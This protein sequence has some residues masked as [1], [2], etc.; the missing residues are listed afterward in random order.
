MRST[1][2]GPRPAAQDQRPAEIRVDRGRMPAEQQDIVCLQKQLRPARA[3]GIAQ[4][5]RRTG[6]AG[7]REVGRQQGEVA[8]TGH[9][10]DQR[11]LQDR[12][13]RVDRV[14][15]QDQPG[16]DPGGAQ[17]GQRTTRLGD[18][19]LVRPDQDKRGGPRARRRHQMRRWKKRHRLGAAQRSRKPQQAGINARARI[20]EQGRRAPIGA[21]VTHDALVRHDDIVSGPF[22]RRRNTGQQP[23]LVE[24]RNGAASPPAHCIQNSALGVDGLDRDSAQR[25]RVPFTHGTARA[26]RGLSP[27]VYQ[28]IMP[29]T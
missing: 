18:S 24:D 5:G 7:R 23:G 16:P 14:V 10:V 22:K 25:S 19:D 12:V 21:L 11:G 26:A 9:V 6:H 13:S 20:D 27:A 2:F 4:A 1:R 17:G 3:V 28:C 8:G 15:H 29:S